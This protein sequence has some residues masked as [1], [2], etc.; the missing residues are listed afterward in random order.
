M[1]EKEFAEAFYLLYKGLGFRV[2]IFWASLFETP[3]LLFLLTPWALLFYP[4][5]IH[6]NLNQHGPALG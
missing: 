2:T 1:G 6:H 3:I 4:L 5:A